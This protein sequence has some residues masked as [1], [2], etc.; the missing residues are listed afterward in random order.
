MILNR[1]QRPW[2]FGTVLAAL[3]LGAGFVLVFHPG[4]LPVRLPPGVADYL[5]GARRHYSVG[6]SPLGLIYGT[7]AY[8]IFIFAALLGMRKRLPQLRLGRARTWLR[9]HVWLTV[10]TVPLVLL[11][12]NARFGGPMT[13]TLMWLYLAVM[14]SGFYGLA[15]QQFLPTRMKERVPGEVIYEQIPF[16][17]QQLLQSALKMRDGLRPA[18]TPARAVAA[19]GG[20]SVTLAAEPA[21]PDPSVA[22]L[23]EAL[24]RNVLPYLATRKVNP[25]RQFLA[26]DRRAEEFFRGLRLRVAAPLQPSV[27]RLATWCEERRQMDEQTRLHH[28]LHGWLFFHAPASFLLVILTGWHAVVLL[29]LY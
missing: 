21:V 13:S 23:R 5:R 8:V 19:G 28:W 2:L 4:L 3:A 26:N 22:A 14:V 1:D 7:A 20:G 10:L 25:A 27:D 11:H 6:N 12:A 24:E 29:F 18:P 17:T 15:L 9:A 16:H